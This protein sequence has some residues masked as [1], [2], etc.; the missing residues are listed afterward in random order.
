MLQVIGTAIMGQTS[1]NAN[2]MSV[3]W[4]IG[5]MSF[6]NSRSFEV[7]HRCDNGRT[8]IGFGIAHDY[9]GY[10]A[11]YTLVQIFKES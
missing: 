2:G 3:S 8:S 11:V 7:R 6:N 9:G 5:R 1:F 4:I 10:N